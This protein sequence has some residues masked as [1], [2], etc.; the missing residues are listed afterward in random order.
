V[1]AW[2]AHAAPAK[3]SFYLLCSDHFFLKRPEFMS[4][5][6]GRLEHLSIELAAAGAMKCDW[7]ITT[8]NA[9]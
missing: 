1:Q 3:F 4:T 9:I 6:G 5:M 8:W 7:K 2:R